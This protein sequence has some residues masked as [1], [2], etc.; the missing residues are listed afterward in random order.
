[1]GPKVA[2]TLRWIAVLP[3]AFAAACIAPT[4]VWASGC[5]RGDSFWLTVTDGTLL[6]SYVV[7]PIARA[8]ISMISIG[9]FIWVGSLI[10]PR[11][12]LGTALVLSGMLGLI[13]AVGGIAIA[14]APFV[15]DDFTGRELAGEVGAF[16]GCVIG[17]IAAVK[18][19]REYERERLPPESE[20]NAG[21]AP[22]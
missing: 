4:F 5:E 6:G 19:V 16:V 15:S 7:V 21:E 2:F 22:L 10:A 12:H 3:G 1:M 11:Y 17:I 8:F 20:Q 13:C 9:A 18:V 14:V